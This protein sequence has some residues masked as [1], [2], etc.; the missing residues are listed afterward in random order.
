MLRDLRECMCERKFVSKFALT[1]PRCC[2]L[3]TSFECHLEISTICLANLY[4]H[5]QVYHV[6]SFMVVGVI[7]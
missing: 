2:Y 6:A 5:S 1:Q 4:K 7:M 3:T